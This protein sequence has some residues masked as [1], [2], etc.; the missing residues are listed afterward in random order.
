MNALFD[1]AS[2]SEESQLTAWARKQIDRL[3]PERVAIALE[4]ERNVRSLVSQLPSSWA[5]DHL[6]FMVEELGGLDHA[7]L[8]QSLTHPVP[9][10]RAEAARM[11]GKERVKAA[12][13]P[14]CALL[15]D[16]FSIVH[17]AGRFD[18]VRRDYPVREAAA[19]ALRSIGM[20]GVYRVLR[21]YEQRREAA[22][23]EEWDDARRRW[24]E[25]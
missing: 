25:F 12:V 4:D 20:G 21:E 5:E 17:V 8:I 3:G 15:K 18:P 2:R 16:D 24:E 13:E 23:Q 1:E 9:M 11:L 6:K 19:A 7:A 10:V 22:E 14:L